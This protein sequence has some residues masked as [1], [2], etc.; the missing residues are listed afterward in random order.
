MNGVVSTICGSPII[1][2]SKNDKSRE[3]SEKIGQKENT[4]MVDGILNTG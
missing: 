4:R 1:N 3:I 2:S